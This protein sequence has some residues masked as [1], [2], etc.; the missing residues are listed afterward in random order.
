M[1]LRCRRPAGAQQSRSR[2]DEQR[3]TGQAGVTPDAQAAACTALI[4]SEPLHPAESRDPAF[5]PRH[6]LRQGRRLRRRHRRFRR[7]A[8]H[9][10]EPRARLSQPRQRRT[11][12]GATT[13]APSPTS[14]RRSGSSRRTCRIVMSRATAYEAKGDFARA[15]ADYDQALKLDPNLDGGLSSTAALPGAAAAIST[16]PSPTS[17]RSSGSTARTSPPTTTAPSAL[18][19]K[20][21]Y[22]RAVADY[23]Q[24]LKLDPKFALAYLNRGLFWQRAEGSRPRH[25]RFR[26]RRSAS[27]PTMRR[28]STPAALALDAKG[29]FDRALADFDRAI[30][31]EPNNANYLRQ[32]RQRLAQPRPLRPRHRGL[33]QGD[34]ARAG[35]CLRLLQPLAGALP[36]RPLQRGAGRRR[37]GRG[38]QRELGPGAQPARA[39]PGE[40][41][42]AG[43]RHR[44]SSAGGGARSEPAAAARCAAAARRDAIAAASR[45]RQNSES[46]LTR[47]SP[48][49]ATYRFA[50]DD[51]QQ[52]QNDHEA[53]R[54]A[55]QPQ[56]D[57]HF[58][59]LS[60]QRAA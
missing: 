26:R 31:L 25:R 37:Q 42:R 49:D 47:A 60:V 2:S 17:I 44:R 13:I 54:H 43:R 28:R 36:G 8:A 11:S 51:V 45:S 20:R 14:A 6:R 46:P 29:E 21:D 38:A 9:Q 18:A 58:G 48:F 19:D 5:Q 35:L 16:A 30:A 40:A 55:Q 1:A 56:D 57:G 52:P 15:I 53:Q 41:R 34:R 27:R 23:D 10:P 7:G 22:D 4:D 50:S 39:D 59:L 12:P 24:A 32:P 3:C 33:R